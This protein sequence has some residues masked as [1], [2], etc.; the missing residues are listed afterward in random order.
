[1]KKIIGII[2]M[3]LVLAVV[4]MTSCK[5]DDAKQPEKAYASYVSGAFVPI[6]GNIGLKSAPV[7]TGYTFDIY[8]EMG[9]MPQ[10]YSMINGSEFLPGSAPAL[11]W[12]NYLTEG[13]YWF[14][15]A[16][17]VYITYCPVLPL[18]VVIR[19]TEGNQGSAVSY[20]GIRDI[21]PT[22]ASFPISVVDRR[23]GDVLT[24]NTDALT[25]LPGYT[26][27]TFTVEY[28]KSIIDVM[29][30][31]KTSPPT[32]LAWPVFVYSSTVP[33]SQLVTGAGN[34]IVY[35]G[36]DAKIT[37]TITIKIH[38]DNTTIVKTIPATALGHGMAITL[39]TNKVGWYD[40][41]IIGISDVDIALD[42][43]DVTI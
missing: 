5:K 13:Q 27:L 3:A 40:S 4:F 11:D 18:R 34:Q 8:K 35:D 21:T 42:L 31:A 2:S 14:P 20:L 15:K 33:V 30:T 23:L 41:G 12:A 38:V 29:Q 17:G 9:T 37:G 24:L 43:V 36:L 22:Q 32:D 10:T 16:T 7:V 1:M 28:T 26:N 6:D 25:A 39:K 19:A